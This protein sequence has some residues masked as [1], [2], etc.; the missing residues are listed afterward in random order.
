MASLPKSLATAQQITAQVGSMIPLGQISSVVQTLQNIQGFN[1]GAFSQLTGTI[2]SA[3]TGFTQAT[4]ILQA[5]SSQSPIAAFT[6]ALGATGL[7]GSSISQL[8]GS[9]ATAYRQADSFLSNTPASMQ[10]W[11]RLNSQRPSVEESRAFNNQRAQHQFPKDIGKYWIFLGFESASISSITGTSNPIT[12]RRGTDSIILPVPMN[13]SDVNRLEYQAVQ[14]TNTAADLAVQGLAKAS[15]GF[16]ALIKNFSGV[17]GGVATVAGSLSGYNVNTAQTLKFVQP[18]LKNHKFSWK[19]V[20]SSPAEAKAIDNI[21]KAIKKN[22][23]PTI[24][25]GGLV[26]KYPNLVNVILYND[27]KMYRFKPAYVESFS[28]NFTPEGGP[29]FHK[30]E[31]PVAVQIDMQITENAVWTSGNQGSF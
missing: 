22:I 10:S 12:S 23:Y 11:Q 30:D 17:L 25:P 6:S 7:A 5:F 4:S 16:E 13:L 19:L 1:P 14:L 21:I 29:A 28:V 24:M 26:F 8:A 2:Q 27:N 15:S 20:P 18:S 9:A 3:L 31:Y